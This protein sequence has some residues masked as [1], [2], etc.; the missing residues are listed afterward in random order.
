MHTLGRGLV[1]LTVL[2]VSSCAIIDIREDIH[3]NHHGGQIAEPPLAAV[4]PGVTTRQWLL[5]NLGEP[6]L[7]QDLEQGKSEMTYQY[8]EYVNSKTRILF[9]FYYRSS[10]VVPR[11]LIVALQDNIVYRVGPSYFETTDD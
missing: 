3:Y 5:E 8:E 2:I 6:V 9:V 7:E 4:V 10:K 11:Q 1:L